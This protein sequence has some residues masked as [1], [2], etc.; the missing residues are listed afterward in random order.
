[1]AQGQGSPQSSAVRSIAILILV[2][3]AFAAVYFLARR[4]RSQRLD[5][6]A[7]CLTAKQAKMYG[8]LWCTH[9]A[10]Q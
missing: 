9:C 2:I 4:K 5:A 7:Q 3:A 6:F 8:L 1:M 10:D